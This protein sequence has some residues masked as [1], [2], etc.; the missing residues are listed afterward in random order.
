M[1]DK[2]GMSENTFFI[3]GY[4]KNE[5]ANIDS[6]ELKLAKKLAHEFLNYSREQL[7]KLLQEGKL[8]E[9]KYER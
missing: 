3:F 9:V 1:H 5:K 2:S 8:F 7:N 4:A 6:E